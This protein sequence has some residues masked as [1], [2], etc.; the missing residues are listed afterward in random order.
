MELARSEPQTL[1]AVRI[2]TGQAGDFEPSTPIRD[3]VLQYHDGDGWSDIPE[4][5]TTDNGEFDWHATFPAVTT[6]RVRLL[7]TATPGDLTRIWEI[8]LYR[9]PGR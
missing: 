9:T 6:R 5:K 7:V 2:I 8:E 4:T 1:G 3:F